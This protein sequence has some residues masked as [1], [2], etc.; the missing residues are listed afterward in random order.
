[1]D[2]PR[3]MIGEE[4]LRDGKRY[5]IAG[6]RQGPYP[7]RLL[8]ASGRHAGEGA[9]VWAAEDELAPMRSYTEPRDD[10]YLR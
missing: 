8:S 10:T 7:Y 4:V 2:G 3:Y 9:I 6:R 5:V 1:M